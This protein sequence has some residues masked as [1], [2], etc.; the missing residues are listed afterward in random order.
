[1]TGG[2]TKREVKILFVIDSL[3]HG[4]AERSLVEM[5][6]AL[7]A[8]GLETVIVA[9]DD[10]P[11]PLTQDARRAG[12]VVMHLSTR[13]LLRRVLELRRI[14]EREHPTIVHTTLFLSDQIGRL[15]AFGTG[16]RVVS[17]LVNT[18]YD[19]VRLLDPNVRR[20]RLALLRLIDGWTARHLTAHLHAI[21]DAV[22]E[23]SSRALGV[24]PDRI[25]VVGRGR[26]PARLGEPN[27]E[28]RLRARAALGIPEHAQVVLNVGRQEYQKGQEYLV[29]AFDGLAS[30]HP[31]AVLLIAGRPGH[32]T[33]LLKARCAQSE[34]RDRIHL[35]GQ[36]DDVPELLA[37]A[38]VFA[39]PSRYEGF[40]GALVEAMALGVPAVVSDISALREVVEGTAATLVPAGD[41]EALAAGL[42]RIL[43][44]PVLAAELGT[45]ARSMFVD[46]LTTAHSSAQMLELY[47]R[48]AGRPVPSS[49]NAL[50]AQPRLRPELVS[51]VVP[52]LNE[53]SDLPEQLAALAAQT[54]CGRWELIVCDNGSV[55]GTPQ[56]AASWRDR[57]PNLRLVDASDRRGINHAR[58]I[59]VEHAG[60]DFI[61]FCDGD[62]VVRPDW[63]HALAEAAPLADIVGGALDTEL[64]NGV[65]ATPPPELPNGL[66]VKYGFLPCVA[67]GNCG[68]WR[69]VATELG[70]DE[71]FTFGGS[72]VEFAWRAQLAGYRVAYA[73]QALISVRHPDG[74]RSLARQ[75]YLYGTS[76]SKLFRVFRDR[77]MRRSRVDEAARVWAWLLIHAGSVSGSAEAR[78]RWVRL[79][80]YRAGR[81]AG[82]VREHTLFL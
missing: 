31:R 80:S 23:S 68:V 47:A 4:G 22:K 43:D 39:F 35:L 62:D 74:L 30:S 66:P 76:E 46:H 14:I 57:L 2:V 27:R 34:H 75:W 52:V 13:G 40:G 61:A 50:A 5:I 44:D 3:G 81:L 70:W 67:G 32:A 71:Q 24:A 6:P 41:P 21:T 55:D 20:H 10:R 15:A 19:P 82:S 37:A 1:M 59:G 28:R 18:I 63:L 73:P 54:Y 69:T 12:A 38:D 7:R 60:G 42:A 26:D 8:A 45:R 53:V 58:N 79:A 16:A 36:R 72:D 9:L 77:G 17:S 65:N 29:A 78:R 33:P 56:L 64:L 49:T 11:G 51:V 48:I 25:T